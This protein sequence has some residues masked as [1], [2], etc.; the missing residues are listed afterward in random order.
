MQAI[1]FVSQFAFIRRM[2]NHLLDRY[3]RR[4]RPDQVMVPCP[5][6]WGVLFGSVR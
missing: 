5:P 3:L 4:L 6:G 1:L 2:A